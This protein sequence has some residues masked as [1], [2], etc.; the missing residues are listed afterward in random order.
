MA[1]KITVYTTSW[2]G[3]CRRAKAFL[4]ARNVPFD[5]INIEDTEGAAEFVASANNGKRKVPTFEVGGRTFHCSPFDSEVL[6]RE[7]GLSK[8]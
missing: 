2:C 8:S 4:Q 6:V 3:D 1:D 7:L 5:E